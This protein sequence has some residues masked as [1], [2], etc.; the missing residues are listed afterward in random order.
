MVPQVNLDERLGFE[1]HDHLLPEQ[2]RKTIQFGKVVAPWPQVL[3]RTCDR[4]VGCWHR[5]NCW[6]LS[7]AA[8]KK[9]KKKSFKIQFYCASLF[10][11]LNDNPTEGLVKQL[12]VPKFQKIIFRHVIEVIHLVKYFC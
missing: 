2:K 5:L 9:K 4:W 6:H 10:F 8:V 1:I 11:F 3:D 7:L 12:I